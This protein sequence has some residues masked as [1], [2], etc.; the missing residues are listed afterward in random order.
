MSS[1]KKSLPNFPYFKKL[2]L[3]DRKSIYALTSKFPPYS[4]YSFVSLWSYDVKN[5]IMISQLHQN[6]IVKLRDYISG[7]RFYSFLGY[8]QAKET[9]ETLLK[10]A[11]KENIMPKLR[12]IPEDNILHN[13]KL[14]NFFQIIEDRD[15]FDYIFLSEEI[16][17]LEGSR[18]S[19]KRNK[20]NN[21]I[22]MNSPISVALLDIKDPKIHKVIIDLC[23]AW[24]KNKKQDGDDANNELHAIKRLLNSSEFL[25]VLSLGIYNADNKLIGF[26]IIETVHQK[27]SLIHFVKADTSYIGLFEYIYKSTA[28]ELYKRRRKYV[29]RQQDLGIPGLRQAKS[30]WR[31]IK[32]LKKY[33]ISPKD[34]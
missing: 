25:N 26:S 17:K 21:F 23:L 8:N 14:F 9:I 24:K 16:S 1:I 19:N 2:E 10:H 6:L 3:E 13:P 5:D 27:N 11:K 28:S 31:P 32:F 29:N 18:F 22:K 4:D 33:I 30:S 7:E 34:Y 20:V 15:N 12:L